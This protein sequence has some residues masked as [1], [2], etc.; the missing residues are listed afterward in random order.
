MTRS[1]VRVQFG[2]AL[3][4]HWL[5]PSH[6]L[7]GLELDFTISASV[8]PWSRTG[9]PEES[10]GAVEILKVECDPGQESALGTL[11]VNDA[12]MCAEINL[13]RLIDTNP[14]LRTYLNGLARER[15]QEMEP[16][17]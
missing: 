9:S 12:K 16:K 14:A 3:T 4:D 13:E 10:S 15:A 1:P 2:F 11:V 8:E 6:P 7:H 5:T 17:Q